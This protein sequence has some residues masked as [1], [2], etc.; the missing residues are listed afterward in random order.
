MNKGV[1]HKEQEDKFGDIRKK[2]IGMRQD[3][4]REARTEIGQ[5][6][7]EGDK[8]NGVS[9]DGDLADVAFRDAIQ[10]AKLTRHQSR[11]RDIEE[12]LRKIDEGTFGVCEDCEGE[13]P[14]GRL[15]AVPFALLCVECQEKLEIMSSLRDEPIAHSPKGPEGWSEE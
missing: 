12:A 2:L 4:I 13:I 5:I 9:D 6:L 7:N 10:A 8:F 15:N 3:L 14:V 11:L 1:K